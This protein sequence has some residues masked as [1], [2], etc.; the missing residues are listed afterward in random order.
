M[1]VMPIAYN[2]RQ[3]HP[4]SLPVSAWHVVSSLN[5][6]LLRNDLLYFAFFNNDK[7]GHNGLLP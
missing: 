1:P 7:S 5:L 6:S 2:S 4:V 3:A